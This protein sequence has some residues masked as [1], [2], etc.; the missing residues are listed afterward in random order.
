MAVPRG[1][2][3][4]ADKVPRPAR[5]VTPR[6]V[7]AE[8]APRVVA[9]GAAPP[10][11]A[12]EAARRPR[13]VADDPA[14]PGMA[15]HPGVGAPPGREARQGEVARRALPATVASPQRCRYAPER[16]SRAATRLVAL[17][18]IAHWEMPVSSIESLV[19]E[20]LAPRAPSLARVIRR[21]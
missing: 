8:A 20:R 17:W 14:P 4:R 6:E 11:L 21:A 9:E 1:P 10:D 16:P 13:V 7:G 12:L 18:P 5:A 3:D 15:A 2:L 19:A